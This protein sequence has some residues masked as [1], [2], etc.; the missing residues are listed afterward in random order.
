[1][2][3]GLSSI[4]LEQAAGSHSLAAAA[5]R[6]RS[7]SGFD[8]EKVADHENDSFGWEASVSMRLRRVAQVVL[9]NLLA[10]AALASSGEGQASGPPSF[11]L[12]GTWKGKM[13]NVTPGQTSA[14]GI[15]TTFTFIQAP[16]GSLQG[17][18]SFS[19]L[20]LGTSATGVV[21]AI[22]VDGK[23]IAFP[24]TYRGGA[25]GVNG[26][27]GRYKLNVVGPDV[28]EGDSENRQTGSYLKLRIERQ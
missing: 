23:T 5:Q 3:H 21:D 24:L 13:M 15:E 8:G 7:L 10:L 28:L 17:T 9:I 12:V 4:A 6:E 25:S 11:D 22:V 19:N 1:M 16:S 20:D 2:I 14:R 27:I 18:A 26:T